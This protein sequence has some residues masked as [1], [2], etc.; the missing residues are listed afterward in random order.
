MLEVFGRVRTLALAGFVVTA[1]AVSGCGGGG[2]SAPG[3]P[4][5]ANDGNPPTQT[6]NLSGGGAPVPLPTSS[7]FSGTVTLP[8]PQ[9]TLPANTTA[10]ESV[11]TTVSSAGRLPQFTAPPN[12]PGPFLLFLS[13]EFSN[14]MTVPLPGFSIYVPSSDIIPGA[15]YYL[16]LYDPSA[17]QGFPLGWQ[18]AVEGPA[19]Q[20]GNQLSFNGARS[21]PYNETAYPFHANSP[22]FFGLYEV[23]AAIPTPAPSNSPLPPFTLSQNQVQINGIGA[24]ANVGIDDPISCFCFNVVTSNSNV[25]TAYVSEAEVVIT[26]VSPGFAGLTVYAAD[27]RTAQLSVTVTQTNLNVQGAHR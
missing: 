16:A 21:Y 12:P 14:D 24:T 5:P 22:V 11:A 7:G 25:A 10:T 9:A 26:G 2:G 20:N 3:A 1:V 19:S 8:T 13:L 27:G 17:S 4:A 6:Q 18:Y 15:N 23:G